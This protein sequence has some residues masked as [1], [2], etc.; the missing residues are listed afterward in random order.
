MTPDILTRIDHS[1]TS[2]N[3][4]SKP[5]QFRPQVLL[6]FDTNTQQTA[7]DWSRP[8]PSNAEPAGRDRRCFLV[9]CQASKLLGAVWAVGTG[10]LTAG[11]RRP[12]D[13]GRP[14]KYAVRVHDAHTRTS[15]DLVLIRLCFAASMVVLHD[16]NVVS[17]TS[18]VTNNPR[19]AHSLCKPHAGYMTTQYHY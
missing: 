1:N 17:D 8:G 4:Q 11:V 13:C 3:L 14:T 15:R 16:G 10:G 19:C 5:R 12:A 9:A 7:H 2:R 6:R 18:R